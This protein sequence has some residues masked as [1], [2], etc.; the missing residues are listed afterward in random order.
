[1]HYRDFIQLPEYLIDTPLFEELL[2]RDQTEE[3]DQLFFDA[4]T[5]E[6]NVLVGDIQALKRKVDEVRFARTLLL[7]TSVRVASLEA[8]ED[9]SSDLPL[10]PHQRR[11][12]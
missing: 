6:L 8:D 1:M 9:E 5:G 7:A 2:E 4:L 10:E 11:T 3:M 12:A